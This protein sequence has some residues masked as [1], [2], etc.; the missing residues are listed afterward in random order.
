MSWFPRQGSFVRNA[1][2]V[3][4]SREQAIAMYEW[5]KALHVIAVI[6]WMAGMLY[7]PGLFVYHC[8][9]AIGSKQSDTFK[10][11]ERG[12]VE[13]LIADPKSVVL[14]PV[15]STCMPPR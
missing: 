4:T 3:G 14:V 9:A 7:L 6:S 2:S 15:H 11:M 8:E 13:G 10:V 12:A 1:K 5:I